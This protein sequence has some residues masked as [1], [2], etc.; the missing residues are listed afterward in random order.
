MKREYELY[1]SV[2]LDDH[3]RILINSIDALAKIMHRQARRL[4]Y[5]NMGRQANPEQH[6]DQ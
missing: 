3:V 1:A 5:S 2:V 4:S 6:T